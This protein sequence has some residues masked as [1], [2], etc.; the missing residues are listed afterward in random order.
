MLTAECDVL[1][2]EGVALADAMVAAGT[3]VV[4]SDYPGMIHG[5]FTFT[6][7]V[8][9]A[10]EAQTELR[11]RSVRH[12]GVIFDPLDI[13]RKSAVDR[14]G[15]SG[16]EVGRRTR[17]KYRDAGQIFRSAPAVHRRS[18]KYVF[19]QGVDVS[20]RLLGEFRVDPTGQAVHL[21]IV[22]SPGGS[23]RLG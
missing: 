4:K 18:I 5:F 17:R 21:N 23:E 1:H 2:D 19:V 9:G 20:A 7:V 12:S 6:P 14:D 8:D 16:D 11:Q 10:V 22:G 3:E 15:G 13:D